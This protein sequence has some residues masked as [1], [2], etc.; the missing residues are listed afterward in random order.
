[1]LLAPSAPDGGTV[2]ARY[3][4]EDDDSG[5]FEAAL[6]VSNGSATPRDWRVELSFSGSIRD[7][8][9]YT[10]SGISV[11]SPST[12]SAA[13]SADRAPPFGTEPGGTGEF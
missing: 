13:T 7:F 1:M 2:T 9:A 11:S 5:S 6:L 8:Q 4:L 3:R 12:V 10:G